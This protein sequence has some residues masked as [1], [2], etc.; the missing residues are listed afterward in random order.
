ML[1][2]V[3]D[4]F[5]DSQTCGTVKI[6]KT[7]TPIIKSTADTS[8]TDIKLMSIWIGFNALVLLLHEIQA[9]SFFAFMEKCD[10]NESFAELSS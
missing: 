3:F 10:R 7:I 9:K 4:I 5:K 8:F 2:C 6:N 1:F